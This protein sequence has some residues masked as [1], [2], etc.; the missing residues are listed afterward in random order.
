MKYIMIAMIAVF[1]TACGGD[2]PPDDVVFNRI[3]ENHVYLQLNEYEAASW[4]RTNEYSRLVDNEEQVF[5]EYAVDIQFIDSEA[6][7][8]RSRGLPKVGESTGVVVAVL[9][10]DKWYVSG[11]RYH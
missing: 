1:L 5:V 10:G 6:E 11:K 7:D 2:S 9:R 3:V 4:E 8:A